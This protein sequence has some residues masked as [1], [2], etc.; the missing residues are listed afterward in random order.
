MTTALWCPLIICFFVAAA[1][2][3]V[4]QLFPFVRCQ[5]ASVSCCLVRPD[6]KRGRWLDCQHSDND[7]KFETFAG[8]TVT[9]MLALISLSKETSKL[10]L[11]D[12]QLDLRHRD[13]DRRLELGI[14]SDSRDAEGD[15]LA[16]RVALGKSSL[17]RVWRS[18]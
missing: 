9:L 13:A 4:S 14:L 17:N 5:E 7:C 18:F 3:N 12:R 10:L 11:K 6:K 8:V 1:A 16:A 2:G 15:H